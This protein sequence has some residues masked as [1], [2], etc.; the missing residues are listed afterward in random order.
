MTFDYFV[1][2]HGYTVTNSLQVYISSMR[3]EAENARTAYE[4]IKD[5]P[6]KTARQDKTLIT[7]RGLWHASRAFTEAADSCERALAA[8]EKLTE[9]ENEDT[10]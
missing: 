7:T 4:A 6:A 2:Q 9:P 8:W 3:E 5:D 10:P 1:S